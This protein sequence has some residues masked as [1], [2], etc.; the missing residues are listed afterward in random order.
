MAAAEAQAAIDA[1]PDV[2]LIPPEPLKPYAVELLEQVETSCA[3]AKH[4]SKDVRVPEELEISFIRGRGIVDEYRDH[5]K[6]MSWY[7]EHPEEKPEHLKFELSNVRLKSIGPDREEVGG[8]E[9]FFD[10]IMRSNHAVGRFSDKHHMGE[11]RLTMR[12]RTPRMDLPC[13]RWLQCSW[14]AKHGA[15]R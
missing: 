3:N 12:S 5:M 10:L 11:F 4:V 13:P 2:C 8:P 14:I 9:C 1:V 7:A 6:I 15:T